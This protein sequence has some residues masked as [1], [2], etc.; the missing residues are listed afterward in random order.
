MYKLTVKS[1]NFLRLFGIREIHRLFGTQSH[2]LPEGQ[3]IFINLRRK[4]DRLHV[5]PGVH[6]AVGMRSAALKETVSRT[7]VPVVPVVPTQESGPSVHSLLHRVR[8]SI[9]SLTESGA[10][11]PNLFRTR[12]QE[13]TL[14]LDA[15]DDRLGAD[16]PQYGATVLLRQ[17]LCLSY[18]SPD[19]LV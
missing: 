17:V 1:R 18:T 6:R 16:P 15:D 10:V 4:R 9:S 12:N 13:F 19:L 2:S 8:K 14:K 3:N 5:V 7:V 11:H